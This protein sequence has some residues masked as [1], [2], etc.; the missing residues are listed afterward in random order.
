MFPNNDTLFDYLVVTDQ[1]DEFLGNNES[2]DNIEE[3]NSLDIDDTDEDN[4]DL[5][6]S[7]NFDEQ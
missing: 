1:L 3:D 4:N 6:E 2:D 7:E 5:E